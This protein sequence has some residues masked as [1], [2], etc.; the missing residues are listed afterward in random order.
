[1]AHRATPHCTTGFR[2]LILLHCRELIIPSHEDLKSRV[3]GENL[4]HNRRLENLET[5]L[6]TGNNAV[7]KANRISHQNDKKLYGRKT[8]ARNFDVEELVYVY[9][10]AMKPGRSRKFYRSW[11]GPFKVTKDFLN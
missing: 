1:M 5:S 9:N 6:K 7:A 10:P 4:D 2:P 8:K 3:T 11:A